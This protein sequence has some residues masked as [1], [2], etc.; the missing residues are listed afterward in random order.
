L[1]VALLVEPRQQRSPSLED[2]TKESLKGRHKVRMKAGSEDLEQQTTGLC[3][4]FWFVVEHHFSAR[5]R[6]VRRLRI[7]LD[8]RLRRETCPCL[9]LSQ[10]RHFFGRAKEDHRR[11]SDPQP[12]TVVEHAPRPS[13]AV[14]QHD[15][16]RLT[17]E[18]EGLAGAAN[19]E[20]DWGNTRAPKNYV[21]TARGTDRHDFFGEIVPKLGAVSRVNRQCQHVPSG[22]IRRGPSRSR[23]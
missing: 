4:A 9:H 7:R 13:L 23:H 18:G 6:L 5:S 11:G 1:Q 17:E 8:H 10:I 19:H 20:V 2:R 15:L 21:V 16:P 22:L 14:E 3:E 12:I